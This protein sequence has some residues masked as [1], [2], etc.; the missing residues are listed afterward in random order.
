MKWIASKIKKNPT[1]CFQQCK[2]TKDQETEFITNIE[3][4]IRFI[5]KESNE[6]KFTIIKPKKS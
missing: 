1:H 5:K 6:I 4:M 2:H 3:F